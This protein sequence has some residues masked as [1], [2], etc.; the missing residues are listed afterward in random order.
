MLTSATT[1]FAI[2]ALSSFGSTPAGSGSSV[3]INGDT[4]V[5]GP[6]SAFAPVSEAASCCPGTLSALTSEAPALG[7][8]GTGASGA[9]GTSTSAGG[10]GTA[11]P[12]DWTDAL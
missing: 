11:G 10:A 2:R 8:A 3:G 1:A 7:A 12:T 9:A 5:T 4:S 6:S